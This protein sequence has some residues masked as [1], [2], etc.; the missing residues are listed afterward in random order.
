MASASVV[1][2][3][4]KHFALRRDEM[5]QTSSLGLAMG[6]VHLGAG[7]LGSHMDVQRSIAYVVR[8]R[9]SYLGHENLL[10]LPS[11]G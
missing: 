6:R 10:P 8:D 9:R 1:R 5:L 2:G 3:L 4:C 11:K 7:G